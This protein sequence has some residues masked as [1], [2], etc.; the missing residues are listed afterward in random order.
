M[1]HA[2]THRHLHW[3]GYW[4]WDGHSNRRLQTHD[5]NTTMQLGQNHDDTKIACSA[6]CSYQRTALLE[7]HH[8]MPNGLAAP[9]YQGGQLHR[10]LILGSAS[11]AFDPGEGLLSFNL[12]TVV[13][14]RLTGT[15]TGSLCGACTAPYTGQHCHRGIRQ[16]KCLYPKHVQVSLP[17]PLCQSIASHVLN[18]SLRRITKCGASVLLAS[19]LAAHQTLTETRP[20]GN[21]HPITLDACCKPS[22]GFSESP[23]IIKPQVRS[24]HLRK[25]TWRNSRRR[26]W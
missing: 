16:R 21:F 15:A 25:L 4:H 12:R 19:Y 23:S 11:I 22:G 2:S 13:Q 6:W 18:N 10:S 9:L 8:T 14:S 17:L 3:K 7:G 1:Q 24:S 5:T 26:G 20:W